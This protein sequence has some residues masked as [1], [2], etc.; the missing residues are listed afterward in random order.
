MGGLGAVG[1]AFGQHRSLIRA[2]RKFRGHRDGADPYLVAVGRVVPQ[3]ALGGPA[4]HAGVVPGN[5]R[6]LRHHAADVRPHGVRGRLQQPARDPGN[7]RSQSGG[8]RRAQ[9][10]GSSQRH[11]SDD[12]RRLRVGPRL[13]RAWV[14]HVAVVA[15]RNLDRHSPRCRRD[16][17]LDRG[18]HD[19]EEPVAQAGRVRYRQRGGHRRGRERKQCNNRRHADPDPHAGDSGRPHSTRSCSVRSSF[20][21]FSPGRCSSRTTRRS[22]TLS[23]PL[24]WSRMSRCS[25]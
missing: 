1:A 11:Q 24:I 3:R 6:E 15:D 8:R 23:S 17:R 13:Y 22:S 14:E 2:V 16:S 10:R 7:V 19:R 12:E 20:T 5:R 4:R 18:L 25:R 21:I 9:Y